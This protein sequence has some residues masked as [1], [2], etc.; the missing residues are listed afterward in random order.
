VSEETEKVEAP[1]VDTEDASDHGEVVGSR[2]AANTSTNN[3]VD[4]AASSF[5]ELESHFGGGTSPGRLRGQAIDVERVPASTVPADYPVDIRTEE[6]IALS[7]DVGGEHVDV[8]FEFD[9]DLTDDRLGRLLALK[10]IPADRFAD[11][12]GESILLAVEDG[13][14]VPVVPD[15]SPRGDPTGVYGIAGG[16]GT[17]L[18]TL[19][20]LVVG[21]GEVFS[22]PLVLAWLLAN[23][24]G[25]PAATYLDAWHLRTHTDWEGGPLFWT[26]LAA[27][28]GVNVLS[29][30]AYLASRARAT[31]IG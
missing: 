22:V 27:L 8:Y 3:D 1:A 11:L 24:L 15:E 20:L 28:P 10:G 31:P 17:N 23:V 5:L 25:V 21:L 13:H 29:S 2:A 19:V 16:L 26:A 14:H 18:L 6:V 12:Y 30:A 4:A 9:E 7:L